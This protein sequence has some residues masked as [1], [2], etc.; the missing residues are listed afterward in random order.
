MNFFNPTV[1]PQDQD[2]E[3]AVIINLATNGPKDSAEALDMVDDLSIFFSEYNQDAFKIVSDELKV[4]HTVR[5]KQL[6]ELFG[7]DRL[8]ETTTLLPTEVK[9]AI[10][11]LRELASR[12]AAIM[13]SHELSV[14]AYGDADPFDILQKAEVGVANI[15]ASLDIKADNAEDAYRIQLARI[16]RF[17]DLA[18]RK[19]DLTGVDTGFR[20]LNELTGGF[21]PTDLFILAAR[22]GMGKTALSI[23]FAIAAAKAGVPVG[24]FSLE[25]SKG[26]LIDRMISSEADVDLQRLRRPKRLSSDDWLRITS[27]S[28]DKLPV[29]I[30][31]EPAIRIGLFQAK[32]RAMKRRHDVGLIVA[33]YLQLIQANEKGII[34]E[35]QV[36][37]VTQ[38]LKAT[39]KELDV[40]IIALSQLNRSVETRGGDKRPQLSDL[41]ESGAIEQEAD[42]VSFLYRPEYYGIFNDANGESTDGIAELMI[43]KHRNGALDTVFLHF[44]KHRVRFEN[45]RQR[46]PI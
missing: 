34:R 4:G 27:T 37:Q 11:K 8:I 7:A 5:A 29:F 12:R 19:D 2:L 24:F 41:R 17:E 35:Q 16:K 1:P 9:R 28:F 14:D 45:E 18:A 36:S 20:D 31:D 32:A 44:D 21:Q 30:D 33:D 15:A 6:T 22:P 23:A 39:A 46:L 25:M 43:E 38:G 10:L 13:L 26:Q 42:V 40:P 3:V